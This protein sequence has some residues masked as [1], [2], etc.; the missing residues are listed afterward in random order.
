MWFKINKKWNFTNIYQHL[1]Q[2]CCQ[3]AGT[4][5]P[6]PP[7]AAETDQEPYPVVS[8]SCL[9]NFMASTARKPREFLVVYWWFLVGKCWDKQGL[10]GCKF[11]MGVYFFYHMLIF[12]ICWNNETISCGFYPRIN[13]PQLRFISDYTPIWDVKWLPNGW[14]MGW[15]LLDLPH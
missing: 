2:L 1:T 13:H 9:A 7:S 15:R 3:I 6:F 14:L 12:M 10:H 11:Y 4:A 8:N 5:I